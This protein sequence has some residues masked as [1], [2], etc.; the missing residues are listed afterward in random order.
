M[1]LAGKPIALIRRALIELAGA[2][3][4][5][6]RDRAIDIR[7]PS[8]RSTPTG[9]SLI[10]LAMVHAVG[11]Q[12]RRSWQNPNPHHFSI[13]LDMLDAVLLSIKV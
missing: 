1:S 3:E 9:I 5:R 2:V 10:S 4:S 8:N 13:A 11:C 12:A 7:K 6:L